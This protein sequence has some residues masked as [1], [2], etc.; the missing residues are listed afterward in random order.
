MWE[1]VGQALNHSMTR[2]L[3]Q[4]ASLLPGMAALVVA[5]LVS[6]LVA[7]V[8]SAIVRRS[9]IG[10]DFD[11]RVAQ[12][13]LPA[14]AEWS[15]SNSPARLVARALAWTVMLIGFLIGLSAFDATLTSQLVSRLFGYLPNVLAAVVVLAAG[16]IIARF[17][18]RSVLIGAVNMNLHY[19]RLLSAGLK[20]LVIV[21]AVAMALE[22]LGIG[23]DIIR[24]AFAILFG[25]IVLALAL[26]VGLGSKELVSR[27]LDREASKTTGQN[28]REPVGH[29]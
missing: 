3:S 28:M 14:L 27:S 1:Q 17:L 29:L 21:L 7:W 9:L 23:G 22:H 5:L 10:I 19:A 12:W 15:P 2:M 6:A 18:A 4:L 8:V 13:G 11:R 24:L 16:S 20:W 25:G 26:A